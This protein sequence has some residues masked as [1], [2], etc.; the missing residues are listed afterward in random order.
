MND[1]SVILKLKLNVIK[2]LDKGNKYMKKSL[3]FSALALAMT[4]SVGASFPASAAT[5]VVQEGQPTSI[6]NA[7]WADHSHTSNFTFS[8]VSADVLDEMDRW[9][10]LELTPVPA[11]YAYHFIKIDDNDTSMK[12]NPYELRVT[13]AVSNYTVTSGINGSEITATFTVTANGQ[14]YP[15]CR[16]E[17]L[18]DSS[19][20]PISG[21]DRTTTRVYA[22]LLPANCQDAVTLT[23]NPYAWDESK[24]K[25]PRVW[26]A[27]HTAYYVDM[28][29]VLE[30]AGSGHY[31]NYNDE[32]VFYITGS[33]ATSQ[34][35]TQQTWVSDDRGWRVQNADGTY[36]T[37]QWYQSNNLWYYLGADSYMLTSTTTPDGYTVNADGVWVQ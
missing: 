20:N 27:D 6:H 26:N 37:N 8:R 33:P 29:S 9:K 13:G 19:T 36:L 4:L 32:L 2:N 25:D 12:G 1:M 3:R 23:L 17:W 5:T 7:S 31:V 30:T 15:A 24:S 10:L 22:I 35:Q 28:S 11:G 14:A 18:R 16:L 21:T 34:P